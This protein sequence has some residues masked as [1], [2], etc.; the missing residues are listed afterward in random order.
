MNFY[1]FFLNQSPN[2]QIFKLQLQLSEK[3]VERPNRHI[4]YEQNKERIELSCVKGRSESVFFAFN[5]R[6][7]ID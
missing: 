2:I 5:E 3:R 1:T 4:N 6:K 7:Q